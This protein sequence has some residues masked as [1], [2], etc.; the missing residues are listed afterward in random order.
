MA[1]QHNPD[2]GQAGKLCFTPPAG[3]HPQDRTPDVTNDQW[4]VRPEDLADHPT[5]FPH[6]LYLAEAVCELLDEATRAGLV[7]PAEVCEALDEWQLA[8]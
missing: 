4:P 3:Q 5:L 7:L 8:R 6:R 2:Q 1:G